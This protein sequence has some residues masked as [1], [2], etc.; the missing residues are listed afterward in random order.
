MLQTIYFPSFFPIL[1]GDRD[2]N[3]LENVDMYP[4]RYP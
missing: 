4:V 1:K 2:K 3:S